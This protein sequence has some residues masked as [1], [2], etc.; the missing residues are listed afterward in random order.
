MPR[1]LFGCMVALAWILQSAICT[2]IN[3]ARAQEATSPSRSRTIQLRLVVNLRFNNAGR[4]PLSIMK[5]TAA[6]ILI[7]LIL[8]DDYKLS[9]SVMMFGEDIHQTF[10]S[11]V[12]NSSP[13]Q[14]LDL[15]EEILAKL[16]CIMSIS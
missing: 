4:K 2:Q 5:S 7:E 6:S 13:K 10:I 9:A 12:D 11:T 14:A 1:K 15:Y 3:I 8:R 16:T